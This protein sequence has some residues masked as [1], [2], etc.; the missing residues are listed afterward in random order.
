MKFRSASKQQPIK[1]YRRKV[2]VVTVVGISSNGC[3]TL[4]YGPAPTLE[5][6]RHL[7]GWWRHY[8]PAHRKFQI[9]A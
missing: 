2:D 4:C 5:N 3:N 6:A 8:L 1:F 9:P 7:L